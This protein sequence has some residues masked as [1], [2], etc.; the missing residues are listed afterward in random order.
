MELWLN[1]SRIAAVHTCPGYQVVVATKFCTVAPD[2]CGW[3]VWHFFHVRFFESIILRRLLDIWKI[4]VPLSHSKYFQDFSLGWSCWGLKWQCI[5]K[6]AWIIG[7]MILIISSKLFYVFVQRQALNYKAWCWLI[8]LRHE[9]FKICPTSFQM[10]VKS[11]QQDV[12]PTV[13]VTRCSLLSPMKRPS[14][15]IFWKFHLPLACV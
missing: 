12:L 15:H 10:Y 7:A 9:W 8:K 2:V 5:I 1:Q 4:S 6:C 11:Y 14:L 3:S 13:P